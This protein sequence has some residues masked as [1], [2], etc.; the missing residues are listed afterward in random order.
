MLLAASRKF[1]L[2]STIRQRTEVVRCSTLTEFCRS[3]RRG[4]YR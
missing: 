3:V 4:H 2:S 1:A